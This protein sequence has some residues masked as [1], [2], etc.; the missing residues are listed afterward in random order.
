M[1]AIA[2]TA[3]STLALDALVP[4]PFQYRRTA[5]EAGLAELAESIRAQGLLQPLL[6]RPA[7]GQDGMYELVFGHRRLQAAALAGLD[8]VPVMVAAMSDE[9]ARLAQIAENLEREDVHPIEEGE[10]FAALI[11]EHGHTREQIAQAYGKSLSYVTGRLKLLQAVPEVRKACLAGEIGSEVALLVARLRT[12]ELQ[13]K[14]LAAIK[15]QYL[16]LGEGGTRSYRQ[17]RELLAEKFTLELKGALFD[18]DDAALVPEAGTCTACP[19]RSGNAP[20]FEDLTAERQSRHSNRIKGCADLC[21]DPDCWDAKTKRHHRN[22]AE[23]LE[24]EGKTV[25]SGS[26]ARAAISAYGEL[27]PEYVPLKDV[28]AALKTVAKTGSTV[29]HVAPITILDPR[30]NKTHEVVLAADLQAAGVKPA[31]PA[32]KAAPSYREQEE[33]WARE[34]KEREAKQQAVTEHNLRVL[35]AVHQAIDGLTPGMTE[36]RLIARHLAEMIDHSDDMIPLLELFGCKDG[37]AFTALP[38]QLTA[39]GLTRFII[40]CAVSE[41]LCGG[42][43]GENHAKGL[44][45]YAKHLGIDVKALAQ[46]PAK[47]AATPAPAA[48]A[49]KKGSAAK[50]QARYRN[51][52]TGE[53]WSGK[54]LQ[55]KWLKAALANGHTLGE[56]DTH[57][58]ELEL[59]AAEP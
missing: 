52:M 21:T 6:A 16:D 54:G 10:G 56:F 48:P 38:D 37:R 12:P 47:P 42:Y 13:A 2:H 25:I 23:A 26:K 39:E 11:A 59:E 31:K 45:T 57:Q 34:R 30:T 27:K 53:T 50:S 51:R 49:K 43:G 33:R 32:A 40:V 19:K 28:R 1:N 5:S 55:P 9:Q 3:P 14:A 35:K 44:H 41:D 36:L 58:A 18:I 46:T 4:S 17:I 7:T 15:S 24:R 29:K 20:E 22:R 8:E